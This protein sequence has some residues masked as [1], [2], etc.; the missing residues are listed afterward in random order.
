[1]ASSSSGTA[2]AVTKILSDEELVYYQPNSRVVLVESTHKINRLQRPF[3]VFCKSETLLI[4]KGVTPICL[5]NGIWHRLVVSNNNQTVKLGD[6]IPSVHDYDTPA[7]PK[8][9]VDN[10]NQDCLEANPT[11]TSE[12]HSPLNTVSKLVA[13]LPTLPPIQPTGITPAFGRT[14]ISSQQGMTNTSTP[15]VLTT[16]PLNKP[17]MA[18]Q[19]L[20]TNAS[21]AD[22]STIQL[23]AGI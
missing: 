8:K 5:H 21:A 15:T 1:M 6:L 18:T 3:L 17:K 14:Q 13:A 7:Q 12:Q 19:T 9:D 23:S 10:K 11:K 4:S 2:S 16:H 22:E 20:A